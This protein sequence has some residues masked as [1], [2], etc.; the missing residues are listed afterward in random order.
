MKRKRKDNTH[1]IKK[2]GKG[3]AS[4]VEWRKQ[5]KDYQI[6]KITQSN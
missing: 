5:N 3:K 4:E 6:W 1:P 2:K